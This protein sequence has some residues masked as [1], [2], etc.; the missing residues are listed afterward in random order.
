LLKAFP[1]GAL[2]I[3]LNEETELRKK[4]N[5]C[6]RSKA[7]SCSA[8]FR[9]SSEALRGHS[10]GMGEAYVFPLKKLIFSRNEETEQR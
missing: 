1:E 9:G 6:L 2:M 7:T 4:K 10:E 3:Y 8:C 5:L